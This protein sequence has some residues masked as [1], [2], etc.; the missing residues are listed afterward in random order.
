V[1]GAGYDNPLLTPPEVLAL[2]PR[3]VLIIYQ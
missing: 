1:P 3:P 2:T